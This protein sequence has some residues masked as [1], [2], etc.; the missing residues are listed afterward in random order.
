MVGSLPGP[1]A[2]SRHV[3]WHANCCEVYAVRRTIQG[4]HMRPVMFGK[5]Y[6][7]GRFLP[8]LQVP[9]NASS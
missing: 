3:T 2:V 9:I 4:T 6:A 1:V 8:E 5:L 7:C